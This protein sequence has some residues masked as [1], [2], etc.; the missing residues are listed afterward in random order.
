MRLSLLQTAALI[1][2]AGLATGCH[3][4]STNLVAGLAGGPVQAAQPAAQIFSTSVPEPLQSVATD[5]STVST[6]EH[7]PSAIRA[8][9]T[10]AQATVSDTSAA[11]SVPTVSAGHYC[12]SVTTE[13]F[14]EIIRLEVEEDRTVTGDVATTVLNPTA[15]YYTSYRHKFIGHLDGSALPV[16][17][18]TWMEYD[19]QQDQQ[20][21]RLNATQ[22]KTDEQQLDAIDCETLEMRFAEAGFAPGFAS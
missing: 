20:D 3:R 17:I 12:Y 4:L 21:W 13:T 7:E 6:R 15:G 16:D 14:D 5:L 8:A 10:A 18:T 9:H 1:L 11:P 19:V 2:T 22:I